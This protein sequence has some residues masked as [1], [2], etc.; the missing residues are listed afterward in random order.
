[1]TVSRRHLIDADTTPYYHIICRCVRRAFLCGQ[2]ELSGRDFSHR[3]QWIEDKLMSLSKVFA[4]DVAAYAIMNNHYHLVLHIDQHQARSWPLREVFVRWTSLYSSI[5]LVQRFIDKVPMSEAELDAVH[6]IGEEYR[7]RLMSIS[8]FMRVIN[9]YVARRANKEDNC[10]GRFWESRFKSQALL[11]K[12]AILTCMAYV[13]LNPI[14][15][16]IV[17]TPE[18][19]DYTSI[20]TRL[21]RNTRSTQT[22]KQHLLPFSKPN[23]EY[24]VKGLPLSETAYIELVD[25]TGRCIRDD[26]RGAIPSHLAPILERLNM[27]DH[28][29]LRHTQ[30]F[31]ARYKRVAGTMES[32]KRVA[33]KLGRKWFQVN[34]RKLQPRPT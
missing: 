10:K 22:F 25:W 29:W 4:I 11:D 13:D 9:E 7:Q 8:W 24:G 26:K 28:E 14:R 33:H 16:N 31:E 5:P 18:A 2:D 15:A 6:R 12:T 27:D 23:T 3:R 32:I 17:N 34:G 1:M 30:F 20:Q 19:S 21:N